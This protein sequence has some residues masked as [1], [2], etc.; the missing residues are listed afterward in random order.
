MNLYKAKWFYQIANEFGQSLLSR[1]KPTQQEFAEAG[2]LLENFRFAKHSL[3]FSTFTYEQ[4]FSGY[5]RGHYMKPTQT[6]HYDKG[7][8]SKLTYICIV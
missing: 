2:A 4:V 8:P 3:Q 6:M 5:D 1:F 7:N